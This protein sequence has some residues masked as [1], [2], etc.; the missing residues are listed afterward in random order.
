MNR[1]FLGVFVL[2][3]AVHASPPIRAEGP[4]PGDKRELAYRANNRGVG[5]LE[6]FRP[7]DAAE[8]FREALKIDPGLQI[9]RTNLAIALF[10][11]PDLPQARREAEE[12]LKASPD[13]PQL[14]YVLGLI[15]KGE[16]RVDDARAAFGRVL[17]LDP[18]D[19]GAQI[20]LGQLLM[21]QRQYPEAMAAFRAA[22]AAEP[23]NATAVYNL[24]LA[25]T[26]SGQAEE[27]Q[28]TME[29]FRVLREGGYGTLIGQNYPDQG[30]Y[31]E[32]VASTGAEP[33]LVDAAT[34]SGRF[35]DVTAARLGAA[36]AAAS[37][38]APIAMGRK[39]E[40]GSWN[41]AARRELIAGLGGRVTLFDYDGDGD[42]DLF[43][44]GPT[45]QRLYRNDGAKFVDV[46]KQV[47][48][49]P[50]AGGI[51]AVAGDYDND[52]KPDLFVLRPTGGTLY[53]N[54]G[55]SF[56]DVTKQAG[57]AFDGGL[58]TSAAFV[59]ADHDGDLDLLLGGLADLQRGPGGGGAFPD[60]FASLPSRLFRNDGKGTFTDVSK[61]A[62]IGDLGHVTAVVPTDYDNRRD[63]DL[64]AISTGTAP[65]LLRNMRDGSFREVGAEAGLTTT[66]PYRCAAAADVNKDGFT[67]FLLGTAE[68]DRLV[69]SDGRAHFKDAAAPEH[70]SGTTAAL[71]VDYDNDGLLDLLALGDKAMKLLRNV[72]S[73]WKDVSASAL[74][75]LSATDLAGASL[76]AGDLDG[77]GD[78]D[79]L[80]RTA[81]G[82]I[83]ILENQGGE[84]SRSVRVRLAGLVSNRSAIGAK[85]EARAGSLRQRLET[86]S[87]TPAIAPADVV[88]GLG[89][90]LRADAVRVLWPAGILQTEIAEP[91]AASPKTA[92]A[93]DVK[94]LDRKPSSCPYLYAW[95]GKRFEFITDFM[96]GGEMG[97]WESPGKWNQPDPDEY[98]RLRDDQLVLKDGR[99]ELRVTNELEE[100]LFVDRLALVAVAH[101][102]DVELFPDEGLGGEPRPPFRLQATR[103]A[104]PPLAAVDDHGHD[105]MSRIARLDRVYPDDFRLDR[106]RGYAEEHGLVLDLGKDAPD[107]TRLLLTGW[108]DYAFSSDTMAAHQAGLES[109]PPYVEVQDANG[110]WQKAVEIGVPVGRPQTVIADLTGKWRSS[111]RKVRIV[112]SM[113]IYW[114]QLLVDTSST[115]ATFDAQ[116]L[117]PDRAM[118]NERGYS[119]VVSSDGREPYSYDYT[120]VSWQAPWKAIPGRYTRPGDV[121]EL[122]TVVDDRFVISRPGDEIALSFEASKL[123]PLP[124]GWRRTFLLFAD[125]FSKEMDLNSATPYALEPLPFH[126]MTRYPYAPPERFPMTPER[127]KWMERYNTRLVAT[128]VPA[129]ELAFDPRTVPA[130]GA[131]ESSRT[132]R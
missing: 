82:A 37:R 76:S 92:Q 31:A 44:V 118:L 66:A 25:L 7:A 122:V 2:L 90:H 15:A 73:G 35:V 75:P 91:A 116:W 96:G 39:F 29:R 100:A 13:A 56:S 67:D 74:P 123:K 55:G 59:D 1:S 41:D 40:G 106:I 30:R 125:G 36:A 95:N 129:L 87:T 28:K 62:G 83:R 94:E 126:G 68:G 69:L 121:R 117:D 72:G 12:G 89:K 11:L 97:H 26:R 77:D 120:R 113:R 81:S 88:F 70:L 93:F 112:T 124:T 84:K 98:V 108:T 43:D 131:S 102:A 52:E 107:H 8:A 61:D 85:V 49:D 109:T 42:L 103:G 16:N 33:D 27:A 79:L 130:S 3:L 99:Y 54:T 105:V 119:A 21:Q 128:P 127:K 47:G 104:H 48:I 78:T 58:Y 71:F 23:Y 10:N 4:S 110:R 6:Q 132:E 51:G 80:I 114:D 32:A 14:H 20:N 9:A 101:P 111:S 65:H 45:G 17:A 5:L 34:P 38:P 64:L 53:R 46:T 86:Y 50:A 18:T 57:L 19:V 115:R 60:G 22:V 63:V 24:G